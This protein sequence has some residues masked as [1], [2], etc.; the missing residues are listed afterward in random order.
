M[1]GFIGA[2]KVSVGEFSFGLDIEPEKGSADSGDLEI[3]LPTCLWR[4][5]RQHKTV[6]MQW[7]F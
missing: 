7:P 4:L 6:E 1:R 2:I 5:E 3:D